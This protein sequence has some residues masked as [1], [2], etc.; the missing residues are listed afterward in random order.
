MA[1]LTDAPTVYID[2]TE[3]SSGWSLT[4]RSVLAG[5]KITWGRESHLDKADPATAYVELIDTDGHLQGY[6]S[7]VGKTLTIYRAASEEHAW[8]LRLFNG[9]IDK[10]DVEARWID[11]PELHYERRIWVLKITASDRLADL[12]RA[13]VSGVGDDPVWTEIYG[14]G[15]WPL[16]SPWQRIQDIWEAGA[17]NV[18]DG[19]DWRDPNLDAEGWPGYMRVVRHDEGR[20]LLDMI[21]AIYNAHSLG[22][23]NY[24]PHSNSVLL[25]QPAKSDGLAL[26]YSGD[27][28]RI[29]VPGGFSIPASRVVAVD[30]YQASTGVDE[31]IDV[32]QISAG[33]QNVQQ[34]ITAAGDDDGKFTTTLEEFVTEHLVP[35]YNFSAGGRRELVIETDVEHRPAWSFATPPPPDPDP[36]PD[37]PSGDYEWPFPLSNVT[38]DYGWREWSNSFHAGIDFSYG[39][40]GGAAIHAIGPGTVSQVVN[41]HSGWGNYVVVDHGGGRSSLYAHMVQPSTLTVGTA[42]NT[43]ST[44]G[45]VGNTGNSFG[46][47]LHLETWVNGAHTNPRGW[48]SA[49]GVDSAGMQINAAGPS[50]SD[51]EWQKTMASRYAV[52]LGQLTGHAN[53]PHIRL[54]WRRP[55]YNYEIAYHFLRA[56]VREH[57]IYFPGS[58]FNT[59][60]DAAA[61]HQII[62]G[63]LVYHDGWTLDA[64]LAPALGTKPGLTVAQLVTNSTAEIRDFQEDITLADLGNITIGAS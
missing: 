49:Q 21:E 33:W 25:T 60:L 14:E 6:E 23:P 10:F 42:V 44:L 57:P 28:I 40:I 37:P 50:D 46:N 5:L 17:K 29:D 47:H 59:M 45:Y 32:V 30:G 41:W 4:E 39:G 43:A 61:L 12:A 16:V 58:V 3:Q 24:E 62:G 34:G 56:C 27:V 36:D 9:R 1:A 18:L 15:Y 20:S 48:M 26:V 53:L 54:D 38:S 64:W 55:R 19:L 52:D 31:A 7:L 51:G 2:G 11:D 63:E 35:G 13:I 22:F 8:Q